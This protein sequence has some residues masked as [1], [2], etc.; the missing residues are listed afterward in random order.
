MK[1]IDRKELVAWL[2]L[3]VQVATLIYTI[4]VNNSKHRKYN[5]NHIIHNIGN[6]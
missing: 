4:N 1:N 2:G 5:N 6:I 3:I